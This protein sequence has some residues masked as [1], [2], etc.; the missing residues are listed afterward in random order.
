[1]RRC[2][3][4]PTDRDFRGFSHHMIILRFLSFPVIF[5]I[6]GGEDEGDCGDGSGDGIGDDIRALW[7][8]QNKLTYFDLF[9]HFIM[10]KI[11]PKFSQIV[12]VSLR[13]VTAFSQFFFTPP[14]KR[15][16]IWIGTEAPPVECER[17]CKSLRD[18]FLSQQDLELGWR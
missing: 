11:G 14:L 7:F 5:E 2:S 10:G 18:A 3:R 15:E 9:Y 16:E 12:S 8:F 1:M 17:F 6:K 4:L 13:G